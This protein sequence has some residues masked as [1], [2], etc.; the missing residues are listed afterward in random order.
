MEIAKTWDCPNC[1]YR[2]ADYIDQTVQPLCEKC[3]ESF[4][5]DEVLI[6]E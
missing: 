5:W 3:E 6:N 1:Q 2:N 4:D